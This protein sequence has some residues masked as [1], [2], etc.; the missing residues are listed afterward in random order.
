V[1][2]S[3]GKWLVVP[4]PTLQSGVKGVKNRPYLTSP[5]EQHSGTRRPRKG[6]SGAID[7]GLRRQP[8]PPPPNPRLPP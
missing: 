3:E 8:P 6:A 2:V 4:T 7:P 5:R 1:G